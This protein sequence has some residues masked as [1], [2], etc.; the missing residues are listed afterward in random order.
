MRTHYSKPPKYIPP[1]LV[2]AALRCPPL[3]SPPLAGWLEGYAVPTCSRHSGGLAYSL[4]PC[5]AWQL[6]TEPKSVE[7]SEG[8]DSSYRESS[9][10]GYPSLTPCPT[11]LTP[12]SGTFPL[13]LPSCF[14]KLHIPK[15]SSFSPDSL[16]EAAATE[17]EVDAPKY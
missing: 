2:L 3:I 9:L 4:W 11:S 14:P 6:G 1:P 16:V 12:P 8:L 7:L 5:V 15:P 13:P 17:A 10:A